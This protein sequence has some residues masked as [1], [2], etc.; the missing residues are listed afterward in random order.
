MSTSFE[1]W[2]YFSRLIQIKQLKGVVARPLTIE[3]CEHRS[4]FCERRSQNPENCER[5]SQNHQN[6]FEFY[7]SSRFLTIS[8]LIQNHLS[9]P[10]SLLPLLT[11][12]ECILKNF[13]KRIVNA[14]INFWGFCERRSQLWTNAPLTPCPLD[15]VGSARSLSNGVGSA[16]LCSFWAV[17]YACFLK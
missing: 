17:F 13:L 12:S 2:H 1:F 14:V 6:E 7:A 4:Q 8:F 11:R 15:L 3:N 16:G 5:R 10:Q 9:Q